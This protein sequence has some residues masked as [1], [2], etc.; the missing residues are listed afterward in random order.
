MTRNDACIDAAK[1]DGRNEPAANALTWALRDGT[2]LSLFFVAPG[3]P[4]NIF[5]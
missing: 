3:G 5:R 4:G 1:M 2:T